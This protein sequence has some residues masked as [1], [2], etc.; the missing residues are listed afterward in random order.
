LILISCFISRLLTTIYYSEDIDS[1]RFVLSILDYN[2]LELRPHFP[3]YPVF[4]FFAKFINF[5]INSIPITFSIIGSISIFI[6]IIFSQKIYL[7]LFNDIKTKYLFL[8]IFFNPLLWI[9][10]NRYMSDLFGLSILI[11]T[12]YYILKFFNYKNL[13]YIIRIS[14]LL[15]ILIGVRVS[16]IPF[17]IPGILYL[18][19]NISN[20]YRMNFIIF[21][22]LGLLIWLIPLITITGYNELYQISLR[23][24]NGHFFNWGGSVL[25]NDSTYSFRLLKIIESFWSDGLGGWWFQRHWI[26]F[27]IGCGF[28]LFFIYSLSSI[29]FKKINKRSLILIFSLLCY[30]LWIFFFQNIIYKPRHVIPL[31]PFLLIIINNGIYNFK[32]KNLYR[33]LII[34]IFFIFYISLTTILNWQHKQPSAIAQLKTYLIN[35][36]DTKKIFSSNKLM[37]NYIKHHKNSN[38]IDFI[39]KNRFKL[40]NNYYDLNYTI[41]ST[42]EINSDFPFNLKSV[43]T[44]YHNPY[45][46]RLWSEL[47]IYEYKKE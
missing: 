17:L 11:S 41:F 20:K 42:S 25:S 15:G 18:I 4:C 32:N 13:R 9:L 40:I 21:F 24:I 29:I 34:N 3:G 10:S 46:N 14:F 37:T 27:Y 26:T 1:L 38:S 30:F 7:I 35:H 28:I 33:S 8:L 6:I 43:K 45:V 16:F 31:I 44:F 2:I 23:H 12:F 19:F 39:N 5:F 36:N 47:T 22:L